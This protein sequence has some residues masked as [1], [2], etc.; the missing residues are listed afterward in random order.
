MTNENNRTKF[1][2]KPEHFI[3]YFYI[4]IIIIS[5]SSSNIILYLQQTTIPQI[6]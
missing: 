2:N 1:S 4:V 5:S 3:S 6:Q